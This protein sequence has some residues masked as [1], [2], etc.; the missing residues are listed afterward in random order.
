MATNYDYTTDIP[1][2]TNKPSVDQPNMQTNTNSINSIIG[3]DHITFEQATGSGVDGYHTVIHFLD[4]GSTDPATTTGFGQIFTKT[5]SG[6][7]QLFYQSGNGVI[8]QLTNS[9][10][11]PFNAPTILMGTFA[12][13]GSFTNISAIPA[14]VYG[15]IIFY[16]LGSP[17]ATQIS[18]FVSTNTDTFGSSSRIVDNGSAND[19]PVELNNHNTALFLQGR[20]DDFG[21]HNWPWIIQYWSF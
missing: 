14:N 17:S 20:T 8:T 21:N 16:H 10:G 11:V 4:Q 19:D 12:S 18:S 5:I 1:L 3:T 15:Y 6:D 2:S 9:T 13:T 7:Q